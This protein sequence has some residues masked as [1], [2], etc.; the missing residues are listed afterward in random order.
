M[1]S[2]PLPPMAFSM[3]VLKAMAR[4][5]TWPPTLE[6]VPGVRFTIASCEKPDR[7]SV[8]FLPFSQSVT[9]AFLLILK[10]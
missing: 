1:V 4:L 3:M 2:L 9:M 10:S 6:K 5:L 7:S 8:L